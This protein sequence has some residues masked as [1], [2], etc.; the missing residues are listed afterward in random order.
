M[1][2]HI[3][4]IKSTEK[5]L[6]I[7]DIGDWTRFPTVTNDAEGV[8]EWLYNNNLITGKELFYYDSDGELSELLHDNGKFVGFRYCRIPSELYWM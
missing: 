7:E 3:K 8:V 6:V 1:R 4:F 2:A 5:L